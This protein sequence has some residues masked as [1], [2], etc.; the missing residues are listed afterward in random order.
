MGCTGIRSAQL[1]TTVMQLKPVYNNPSQQSVLARPFQWCWSLDES[2]CP[3]PAGN[4]NGQ[5]G[6]GPIRF[7][8]SGMLPGAS[9]ALFCPCLNDCPSSLAAGS[10]A[11]GFVNVCRPLP[12]KLRCQTASLGK[13]WR[14]P[15]QTAEQLSSAPEPVRQP[16]PSIL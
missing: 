14:K 12:R 16:E 10:N 4:S 9:R 7:G 8:V 2:F 3:L 13:G 15:F 5:T 6:L 11:K 1:I